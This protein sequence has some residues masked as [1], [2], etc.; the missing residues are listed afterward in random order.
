M[1]Y[2]LRTRA[3]HAGQPNEAITGAVT[4]PI[5]QTST[6]AQIEPGSDRGYSYSR[7]DHPTRE[8]LE[9]C[10]A[11]LE[12]AEHGLAYASGM[13][14]INGVL[15]LLRQG[16]HVV[17]TRD[18]YGGAWRI[19]TKL[20]QRFGIDFTFVDTTDLNEVA[21][22][23]RGNTRLLWLE[24]P[25]NPL[26][27]IT[28]IASCTRLAREAGAISVVDNTFATPIL[29]QP[30][31]LG[32]DIVV[33]STTKY[34]NGHSDTVG[35]AV[36]TNDPDLHAEL[37]F[38]QNAI[39]AIPGPQDCFLTL[40]GIKT[41]PLRVTT[42]CAGARQIAEWLAQHP[43]VARVHYP[44]LTGHPGHSVARHQMSDFGAVISFELRTGLPETIKLTRALRLWTLAESLG[45]VKSLFCHPPTMTHASVEPEVRRR[46]GIADG[47]IRLSVGLEDPLD[48][49]EDLEQA[50]G[51]VS[52][53]EPDEV[54]EASHA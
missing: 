50:F 52:V 8:A 34:I 43:A 45:S 36:V 19:F 6:Y 51:S 41:L 26:L 21:A 9:R 2:R 23:F 24:T 32:A 18:L 5:F 4:F 15:V 16:D 3:I 47:L 25:S 12:N 38:F 37:K 39:G 49:I 35:G 14:A 33:H 11:S 54:E 44:G 53:G 48:L 1:S 40:R 30:L 42:H 17:S 27:R 29:Q 22:A 13:A 20:F 46:V 31:S 7:T 28:D 10:I